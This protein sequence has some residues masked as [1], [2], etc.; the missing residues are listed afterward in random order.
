MRRTIVIFILCLL[1]PGQ[2]GCGGDAPLASDGNA[3]L[4]PQPGLV[5]PVPEGRSDWAE[6]YTAFA[7][8]NFDALSESCFG[9][10]AGVGFIDLDLDGTPELVLFD[11][12]AGASMGVQ[13]FDLTEE[14]VVCV[15]AS[16]VEAGL[17]FGDETLSPL[18]ADALFFDDFRLMESEDGRRWFQILSRNG[19]GDFYYNELLRLTGTEG[20]LTL[21][22]LW[23]KRITTDP[24]TGEETG[25][26]YTVG[27]ESVS[28]KAFAAAVNAAE[29]A[30]TDSGYTAEGVFLW[31]D[32]SFGYDFDG[33]MA[34][35]K[36]AAA[37]YV[38]IE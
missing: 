31:S 4:P 36:A 20:R 34:M 21:E 28:D 33:L 9:G 38:P 35:V 15:S 5:G 24:A 30:G 17:T 10:V 37:S 32:K 11:S 18:Y 16:S 6:A 7:E 19:A 27:G 12:G 1:L 25:G 14:G 2:I 8:E 3:A 13:L 29:N 22:S 23:Y 26:V